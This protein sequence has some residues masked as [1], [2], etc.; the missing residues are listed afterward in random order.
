MATKK[1]P[2][3]TT[4]SY[5]NVNRASKGYRDKYKKDVE[6][7]VREFASKLGKAAD[8]SD[9]TPNE[10]KRFFKT[11]LIPLDKDSEK[12]MIDLFINDREELN[13]L[14][15]LHNTRASDNL[16]EVYYKKYEKESPTHWHDLE[17][18]KQM[19]LEGLAIAAQRFDVNSGNKFI[20]YATWW[21]LNRVRKP[22]QEKGAMIGHTSLSS[23]SCPFDSDNTATLE[24]VISPNMMAGDWDGMGTDEA[25][26]NPATI[27]EKTQSDENFD[28]YS[29]IKHIVPESIDAIEGDKVKEM[30]K[31]LMGIVD[32]NKEYNDRQIFLYM[33][34]KIFNK[35]ST[36]YPTTNHEHRVLNSYV[37]EAAKSKS[38]L[39]SR[40]HMDEKQYKEECQNLMKRCYDGL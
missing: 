13:S 34:R 18:F 4:V 24:D 32:R 26:T 29:N 2:P 8:G 17:D 1:K 27:L 36:L 15:I 3:K 11:V 28:F 40:I 20:T 38:E 39:L 22:Y 37:N 12:K 31:Y 9:F 21:V 19:A 33:F 7:A 14:L 10:W 30:T 16:A 25:S 5:V 23:P 6:I 35:C